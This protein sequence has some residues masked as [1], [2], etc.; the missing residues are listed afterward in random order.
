MNSQIKI[1]FGL[2]VINIFCLPSNAVGNCDKL[3]ANFSA[4]FKALLIGGMKINDNTSK[5]REAAL[6]IDAATKSKDEKEC[7]KANTEV[8]DI[9]AQIQDNKGNLII[10]DTSFPNTWK[11]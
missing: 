5:Y 11:K 7:E 10:K 9:L 4:N 1:L 2:L 6:K 8:F 3:A